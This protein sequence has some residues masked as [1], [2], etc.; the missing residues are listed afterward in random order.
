[1]RIY[2]VKFDKGMRKNRRRGIKLNKMKQN[3]CELK[4]LKCNAFVW[5]WEILRGLRFRKYMVGGGSY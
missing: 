3:S 4:G 1:M 5:P 2:I